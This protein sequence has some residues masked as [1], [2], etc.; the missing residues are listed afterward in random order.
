MSARIQVDMFE[1]HLG[2]ALLLQ[3]ILPEGDVV[4]VLADAGAGGSYS[5]RH[6]FEKLFNS[7]GSL[8]DVWIGDSNPRIDL[9]VGTHYDADHLKG[10]PALIEH[11]GLAIGEV[12]LPPVQDDSHGVDVASVE[13]SERSLASLLLRDEDS[14]VLNAYLQRRL[15]LLKSLAEWRHAVRMV[16]AQDRHERMNVHAEINR[17]AEWE[18]FFQAEYKA[19]SEALGE[20]PEDHA[21]DVAPHGDERLTLRVRQMREAAAV[22]PRW[23]GPY[24]DDDLFLREYKGYRAPNSSHMV[25][26]DGRALAVIRK[27]AAREAIT[28]TSLAKVVKA[29]RQRN[30]D[31]ATIIVRSE[32]ISA[33]VPKYFRWRSGQ[34]QEARAG[35]PSELGFHLMGPSSELV[36]QLHDKLPIGAYL[37]AYR[38]DNL[39]SEA[40]TPS[41]RLSYVMRFD[42]D[43]QKVLITGD[44][45]FSDFAPPR[46]SHF[47][48]PLLALLEQL[49]V[50]Q[51][52][53]H[54]GHS[55][56][57]YQ[58][59]RAAKLHERQEWI[60]LMLSHAPND[61]HRPQPQ[62]SS[63]ASLF[64][65]GGG[66]EVSVL[67]T[68]QPMRDKVNNI[69]DLIHPHVGPV[70]HV[71]DVRLSYP[72]SPD[73]K[74]AKTRWRVLSHAIQA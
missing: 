64:R 21:C 5:D 55:H 14:A 58:A 32:T 57:F 40:V 38:A 74:R 13:A 50:L 51:I 62:F 2:A 42:C 15:G 18:D 69:R 3:F 56:R 9:I 4:R 61:K 67:F 47:H 16:D 17:P 6:V 71:G 39:R 11:T 44:A 54:G 20:D 36:A 48:P 24:R 60:F 45:G 30:A 25:A 22:E 46:T 27:S 41:N 66:D 33:G 70:A 52:A 37:L 10:L 35:L 34:F 49:D 1:V 43:E 59:L 65:G 31:G 23:F 7:D 26:V 28:A 8:T 63:F 12:W 53:H 73:L 68:S 72:H 29:I 19:A